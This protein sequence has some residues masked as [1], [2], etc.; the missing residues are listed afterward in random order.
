MHLGPAG[1]SLQSHS[2]VVQSIQLPMPFIGVDLKEP[3]ATQYCQH[4][5]AV[6]ARPAASHV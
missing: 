1:L 6:A 5:S 2:T 3:G 4:V